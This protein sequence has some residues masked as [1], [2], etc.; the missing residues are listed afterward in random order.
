MDEK[1]IFLVTTLKELIEKVTKKEN[2]VWNNHYN[3]EKFWKDKGKGKENNQ[4]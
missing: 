4:V 1:L 3:E 2:I